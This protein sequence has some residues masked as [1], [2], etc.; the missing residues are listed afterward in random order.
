MQKGGGVRLACCCLAVMRI[1]GRCAASFMRMRI[2]I[3][4]LRM[5]TSVLVS[6]FKTIISTALPPLKY[7]GEAKHQVNVAGLYGCCV[8]RFNLEC[9]VATV[10]KAL[11]LNY[12]KA[13][14]TYFS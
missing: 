12:A 8:S 6:N 11:T 14:R 2:T 9:A 3:S 7:G 5:R 1:T 13:N 4:A 10:I